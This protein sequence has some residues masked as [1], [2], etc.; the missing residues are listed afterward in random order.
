MPAVLPLTTPE[1]LTVATDV[2]LLLHAP[3]EVELVSE[4]VAD[5]QTPDDP[6]MALTV[7]V[8]DTVT[9]DDTVHPPPVT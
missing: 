7:G 5:W 9:V 8:V 4:I 1:E 6:L 2:L 3:P